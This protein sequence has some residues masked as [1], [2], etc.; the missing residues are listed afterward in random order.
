MPDLPENFSLICINLG[1]ASS[2]PVKVPWHRAVPPGAALGH[3]GL[4]ALFQLSRL[5]PNF[6]KFTNRR[7]GS[8][9]CLVWPRHDVYFH[10]LPWPS[11]TY[12]D[13]RASETYHYHINPSPVKSTT[14]YRVYINFLNEYRS[15][16]HEIS[17][18]NIVILT[19]PRRFWLPSMAPASVYLVIK[20]YFS[21]IFYKIIIVT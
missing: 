6:S 13:V 18:S 15:D 21:F 11:V 10:N 17:V 12:C 1:A 19:R 14:S 8:T 5:H 9:P 3:A 4:P 20:I 16:G 7:L 2:P